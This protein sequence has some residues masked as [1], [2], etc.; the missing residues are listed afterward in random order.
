MRAGLGSLGPP[1]T[2]LDR[3]TWVGCGPAACTTPHTSCSYSHTAS[4]LKNP[5]ADANDT[6]ACTV[7]DGAA[8]A[9]A[10]APRFHETTVA[11]QQ[12]AKVSDDD[13]GELT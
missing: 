5:L 7:R 4:N 3:L 8:A 9:C 1:I 12:H 10:R 2:L 13:A 11:K 6:P